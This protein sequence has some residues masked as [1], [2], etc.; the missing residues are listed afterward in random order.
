MRPRVYLRASRALV[1]E[2]VA[3]V[4]D[5]HTKVE[6]VEFFLHAIHLWLIST[7]DNSVNRA[8]PAKRSLHFTSVGRLNV[9]TL[10]KTLRANH[11][12]RVLCLKW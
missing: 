8:I 4:A 9:L 12:N 7:H 3:L 5:H 2:V 1:F 10:R 11:E 6:E